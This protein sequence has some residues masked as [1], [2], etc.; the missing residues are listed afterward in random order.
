M[1][2]EAAMLN[3][4]FFGTLQSSGLFAAINSRLTLML[5]EPQMLSLSYFFPLLKLIFNYIII[6]GRLQD[7]IKPRI[8]IQQ[9]LDSS[10]YPSRCKV[11][12]RIT[13]LV[14][15]IPFSLQI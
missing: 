14:I 7:P 5:K 12:P 9:V 3:Y 15:I 4:K 10:P 11:V 1:C 8:S 6:L 13:I 2:S